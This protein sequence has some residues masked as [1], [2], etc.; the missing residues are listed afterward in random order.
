MQRSRSTL[1]RKPS[2]GLESKVNFEPSKERFAVLHPR[3]GEGENF[4]LLGCIFDVNLNMDSC[5]AKILS[6][7][8]P[9]IR[10]LL[11]SRPYFTEQDLI[12]QF[13]THIWSFVE[14]FTPCIYHCGVTLLDRIDALQISFLRALDICEEEAFLDHNVAPLNT[15]RDV[16]ILGFLHKCNLGHAHPSLRQLFYRDPL[17]R[18]RDNRIF[19]L[20]HDRRM[21]DEHFFDHMPSLYHKS[22]FSQIRIYNLLAPAIVNVPSVHEFQS[23]LMRIV[24]R[25]LRAGDRDWK[26]ALLARHVGHVYSIS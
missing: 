4:K 15:R 3:H 17:P 22:I 10:N 20:L 6:V 18:T 26:Y 5:V 1:G 14:Y 12:L 9:K 24:R 7:A 2:P 16:A 13:K 21:F 23:S 25:K 11:R 8:R 19:P